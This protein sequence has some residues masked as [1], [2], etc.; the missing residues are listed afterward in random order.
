M[1]VEILIDL[2]ISAALM[3][4]RG[5]LRHRRVPRDRVDGG[6]KQWLDAAQFDQPAV[7]GTR[8]VDRLHD[9]RVDAVDARQVSVSLF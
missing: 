2:R 9:G 8:F 1:P 6:V 3:L 5:Q 7:N 4:R